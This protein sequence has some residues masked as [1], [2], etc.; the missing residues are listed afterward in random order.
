MKDL[1]SLW[2]RLSVY[3]KVNETRLRHL[4]EEYTEGFNDCA[5][6]PLYYDCEK[7]EQHI[8]LECNDLIIDYLK[9]GN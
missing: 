6:C 3:L 8:D 2:R 1:R 9:E 7:E 4:V 5:C